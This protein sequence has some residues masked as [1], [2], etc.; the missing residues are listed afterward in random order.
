[1]PNDQ[2]LQKTSPLMSTYQRFPIKVVQGKGSIV[3]DDQGKEYLDFTA[4]IGV[5]NLG[6]VPTAVKN[7]VEDQL[8]KVWH[9]SNL[10]EIPSQEELAQLLVDHSFGDQVFFCNSG[11]E[12]NEAAI[13]LARKYGKTVKGPHAHEIVSFQQSFHG[14]TMATL[15]A[16]GQDKVKEGFSP[17]LEGFNYLPYNDLEAL[18]TIDLAKTVAV[19]LELV[20]GE[21]GVIPAE[22]SWLAELERLCQAND[23]L[24]LIDEVQTGCGR[25]GKL[26]AYEHYGLK[27]DIM[28]LAKGLGSGLPIGA[29]VSTKE[30]AE[31]FGPGSH[32]TTFGGNPIVTRAG[33]ATMKE[34]TKE[35]FLET[36]LERAAYLANKLEQLKRKYES[37]QDVRGIGLMQGIVLKDE[38]APYLAKA[39]E[40]GVLLLPA[41]PHV[42]RLLPPL[43]TT[44]EE[45]DHAVAVLDQLFSEEIGG[46]KL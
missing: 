5:C 13:K 29:I 14:R 3:W 46:E 43:T 31:A 19:M 16:T 44:K 9:C 11:A 41:G 27:P 25:T 4:G 6:H 2:V 32:A 21:G 18:Q 26:F 42:I 12:A 20:Q 22:K 37:I 23:I 17:L 15:T 35:G 8:N 34:L 36:V 30:V 10:Y 33:L 38:A 28:S 1:M 24:I 39:R 7:A 40:K 45:I